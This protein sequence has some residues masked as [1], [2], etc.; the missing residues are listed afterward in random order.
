MLQSLCT[1]TQIQICKF[2]K[3]FEK[4]VVFKLL[5]ITNPYF[6]IFLYLYITV[7]NNAEIWH[8]I[9]H[10]YLFCHKYVSMQ[11]QLD[12]VCHFKGSLSGFRQFLAT[13]SPLKVMKNAFYFTVRALFILKIFKFLNH[14]HVEM[15]LHQK[16]G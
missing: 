9:C 11:C 2:F 3:I 1:L 10:H 13:E 5:Q 6:F 12:L 4:F 7:F 15:Q 16:D 8:V 14:D